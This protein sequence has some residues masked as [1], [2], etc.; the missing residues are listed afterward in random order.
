MRPSIRALLL[1][2]SFILSLRAI[3]ICTWS[4]DQQSDAIKRKACNRCATPS[5]G[6]MPEYY[7]SVFAASDA[8]AAQ[9]SNCIGR[10]YNQAT[11]ATGVVKVSIQIHREVA[12]LMLSLSDLRK[13]FHIIQPVVMMNYLI[14]H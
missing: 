5:A 8:Q 6:V 9:L 2:L 10:P 13:A 14:L 11:T 4:G 12:G 3:F 7:F 1:N